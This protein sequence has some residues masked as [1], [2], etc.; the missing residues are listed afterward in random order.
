MNPEYR[1]IG[2]EPINIWIREIIGEVVK[3][4]DVVKLD[5]VVERLLKNAGKY[6]KQIAA[7][8]DNSVY[9][10]GKSA[11]VGAEYIIKCVQDKIKERKKK[12]TFL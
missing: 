8:R 3:V 4:E 5:N 11:E 7:Q 9:N 6:K 10:L 2:V 1:K 12:W